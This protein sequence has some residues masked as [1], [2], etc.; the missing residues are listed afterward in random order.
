MSLLFEIHEREARVWNADLAASQGRDFFG[1]SLSPAERRR[2][3]RF[4]FERDREAFVRARGIL[5]VLLGGYFRAPPDKIEILTAPSGK[6]YVAERLKGNE[7]YF[8]LS[9]S[10][11]LAVYAF[12]LS[13]PVGVDVETLR[14]IPD[15]NQLAAR[16]FTT[17]ERN[18]LQNVEPQA[19]A[20]TFLQCWTR[21][22]AYLKAVGLGLSVSPEEADVSFAPVP[23]PRRTEFPPRIKSDRNFWSLMDFSPTGE[24]VAAL[25]V[26]S[27]VRQIQFEKM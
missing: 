26:D 6:P 15:L 18:L 14:P 20:K 3:E 7:L 5:R 24:S 4:R 8:N 2:A 25:V 21:K 27:S 13:R 9:R 19:R 10:G 22:E 17:G 12:C 11:G 1:A 16:F 23:S